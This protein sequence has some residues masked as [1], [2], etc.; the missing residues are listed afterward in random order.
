M[1]VHEASQCHLIRR[2]F[3]APKD[4]Y[5]GKYLHCVEELNFT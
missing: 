2:T 1:S 3:R 4:I 5:N